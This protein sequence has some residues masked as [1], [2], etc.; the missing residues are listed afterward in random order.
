MPTRSLRIAWIGAGPGQHESGGVPGVAIELL[1]GLPGLGHRVDCFLPAAE[2]PLPARLVDVPG[3][4]F[5]WGDSSWRWKRW[6]NRSRAGIFVTSLIARGLAAVRLRREVLRRHRA[7]PYDLVFQFCDIEALAMPASLRRTVPLV[8]VPETHIA[9]ELRCLLAE[10]RLSLRCQ[11]AYVFAIVICAMAVRTL[12]QRQ[13]IR[14][15]RLLV[16]ISSVFRDHLVHDYRYPLAQTRVIPN[17]VRLERF[18]GLDLAR[19]GASPGRVLVLGRI[20]ARKGIEDVIA[21]TARLRDQHID[22]RIRIVGGPSLWSD[23]TALLDDLPSESAEFV[24]RI[25]PAEI[26]DELA[27]ADVL[28]QAAKYEPF[29]LTVG[30]ALAAGVPVVATSETG[31]IEGIDRTVVAEV[32]PGDVEAMA[33][34]IERTL[35][36]LRADPAALR[37][38]AHEEAT[39]SFAPAT[40]CRRISEALEELIERT[41]PA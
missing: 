32:A 28:L 7:E 41:D 30:E 39:R 16:C 38:L 8:M 35:E 13:R 24:G 4:T 36:R 40:V 6:Y 21:L 27:R 9:G 5:V 17:P 33:R 31:A 25:P 23:Y 14:R 37:T 3:L 15:A 10:R 1:R 19:E 18:V 34:A 26:P 20:S 11:P 29:G 22:A 12:V 2:H